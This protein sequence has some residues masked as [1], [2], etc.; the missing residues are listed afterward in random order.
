MGNFIQEV[1]QV[2]IA[3]IGRLWRF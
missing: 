3:N 1:L 2:P